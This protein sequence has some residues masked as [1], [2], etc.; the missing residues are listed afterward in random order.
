MTR[1]CLS[2]IAWDCDYPLVNFN[3]VIAAGFARIG[4]RLLRCRAKISA[5]GERRLG[6]ET[7]LSGRA[8]RVQGT[9]NWLAIYTLSRK[10]VSTKYFGQS[11]AQQIPDML[12]TAWLGVT[13]QGNLH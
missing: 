5:S 11:L 6:T 12:I 7:V 8:C 1:E 2:V 13:S 10:I 4:C 9:G 3:D